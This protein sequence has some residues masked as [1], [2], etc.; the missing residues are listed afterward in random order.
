[1]TREAQKAPLS[2]GAVSGADWGI[3]QRIDQLTGTPAYEKYGTKKRKRSP[4]EAR[5]MGK[6][7]NGSCGMQIHMLY[8]ICKKAAA[9]LTL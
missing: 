5:F 6:R 1:M 3:Q 9:V 8:D 2:K 4:H 7:K